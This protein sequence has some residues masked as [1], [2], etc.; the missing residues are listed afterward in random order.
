MSLLR[1]MFGSLAGWLMFILGVMLSA[2]VKS[3]ASGA[4]SKVGGAT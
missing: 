2:S 1:E 3:L 4:K